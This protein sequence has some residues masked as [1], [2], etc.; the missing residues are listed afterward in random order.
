MELAL[1]KVG[2]ASKSASV[3]IAAIAGVDWNHHL[4]EIDLTS[5]CLRRCSFNDFVL[6]IPHNFFMRRYGN[7]LEF[8]ME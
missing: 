5:I 4:A 3:I 7:V 8:K 2:C 1:W 6:P